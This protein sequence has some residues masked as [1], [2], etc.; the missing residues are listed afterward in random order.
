MAVNALVYRHLAPPRNPLTGTFAL[1][2]LPALYP[3]IYDAFQTYRLDDESWRAKKGL[4]KLGLIDDSIAEERLRPEKVKYMLKLE[5]SIQPYGGPPPKKARAIQYTL[6]E[7][8]AY[9]F[10]AECWAYSK[11]LC[12]A[13]ARPQKYRVD[14][15][16]VDIL[17]RYAAGMDHKEIGEFA[18]E[19][20]RERRKYP[21]SWI[22]ERD[23]KNWDANVQ[24][25]HRE[26]LVELYESLHPHLG[27][28]TRKMIHVFGR[29]VDRNGH[30]VEVKYEVNGTVKSGHWD[31]GSGNGTLNIEISTQALLRLPRRL[32]PVKVRGMVLGDDYIAWLYFN[33]PVCPYE[34]QAALNDAEAGLGIHPERGLFNDVCCASFISLSF[35]PTTNGGYVA[36]PKVGRL[37][38][39]LFSTVTPLDGRAPKAFASSVARAF[40]PW[41]E[42]WK[43]MRVFLHHHAQATPLDRPLHELDEYKAKFGLRLDLSAVD[44]TQYL[45]RRYNGYPL[46]LKLEFPEP[47][48]AGWARNVIV[49]QLIVHDTADPQERWGCISRLN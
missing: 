30:M 35:A 36:L 41:Y 6:N 47:Q 46:L 1:V 27:H 26:A 21:A 22:D 7:R 2:A 10:G 18:A 12:D 17:I 29:W 43:P 44:W 19:S 28:H 8:T 25:A 16:D 20:E 24:V 9:E 11:A 33:Q 37:F 5:T 23:G 15:Q 48:S 32:R 42:G 3:W 45:T 34:L 13:S 40:L 38:A 39:K 4:V 49:D 14:G 31:T